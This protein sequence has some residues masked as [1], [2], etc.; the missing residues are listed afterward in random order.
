MEQKADVSAKLKFYRRV[1]GMSQDGLAEAS[2]ISI[3]TIQRIEK[4]QSIGNGFTLSALASALQ[5]DTASLTCTEEL[6]SPVTNNDGR[7][8][9]LLNLSAM[10]VLLLPLANVIV[11]AFIFWRKRNHDEGVNTHGRRIL[12]F[13]VL[14]TL[15]TI[16]FMA[17]IPLV[18]ILFVEPLRGS[19]VPLYVPVYGVAVL[20]NVYF[21]IRFALDINSQSKIIERLP[22]IL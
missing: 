15:A 11:P 10:A 22:N 21:T 9:K 4:G 3:R 2:G 12:S 20:V 16:L 14:W 7:E 17:T 5:V 6:K 13:Q 8:L 18:L 1:R 19:R